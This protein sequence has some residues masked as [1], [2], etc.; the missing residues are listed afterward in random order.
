MTIYEAP[1]DNLF[2]KIY[3]KCIPHLYNSRFFRAKVLEPMN[4]SA[5][6]FLSYTCNNITNINKI[7]NNYKNYKRNCVLQYET[8]LEL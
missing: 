3:K 4:S 6:R 2:P 1:D 7:I 8:I 5:V